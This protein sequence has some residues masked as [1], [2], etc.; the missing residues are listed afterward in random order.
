MRHSFTLSSLVTCIACLAPTLAHAQEPSPLAPL[1]APAV[2]PTPESLSPLPPGPPPSRPP[3]YVPVPPPAP[4]TVF[5]HVDAARPVMVQLLSPYDTRWHDVCLSPCDTELP[6]EGTYRVAAPGIMGSRELE[7][8]ATPGERVVLDVN[9]RTLAQHRTAERLTIAGYIAGAAGL[10]L[11]IAALAVNSDSTADAALIW[12]GAGAAVAAITL[13]ITAY[14]M[15]QPSGLSQSSAGPM[16]AAPVGAVPGPLSV[17]QP[18]WTARTGETPRLPPMTTI[19][20]LTST[21]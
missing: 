4:H 7:L 1:P 14:V 18:L 6:L 16:V 3:M 2:A 9:V 20:I 13:A 17:R 15:G 11:E 19:P 10:G 21:F 8:E 5:V 12:S